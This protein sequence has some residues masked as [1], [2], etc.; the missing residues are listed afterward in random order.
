MPAGCARDVLAGH[1][2]GGPKEV[3]VLLPK[4]RVKTHRLLD[5]GN[6]CQR[7]PQVDFGKPARAG[8]KGEIW[9]ERECNIGRGYLSWDQRGQGEAIIA[10]VNALISWQ[11]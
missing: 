1:K 9:A 8:G 4:G 11:R 2:I 6:G 5:E 7:I 10:A 3:E